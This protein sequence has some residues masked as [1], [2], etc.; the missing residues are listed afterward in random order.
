MEGEFHSIIVRMPN[1][2]GNLVMATP[3]LEDLRT[4]FPNAEITAMCLSHIAPL[5][6]HDSTIDKLFHFS[7]SK[8][9]F[10][11]IDERNIVEKLKKGQYDVGILLTNS[12]SSAWRFWRGDVHNKIGFKTQCR[13]MFLD[14]PLPLPKNRARQHLVVTYK[15]LLTPLGIPISSIAP[16]LSVLKEEIQDAWKFVKRFGVTTKNKII[17]ISPGADYGPAKC[18]LPERFREV[19]QRLIKAHPACVIL[20]FGKISQKDLIGKICTNLP[21][22]VINLA[23]QTNLRE[24]MALIKIC[25]VV[26]TNDSGPMHIADS[27]KTP[28]LALFGPTDPVISSPYRQNRSIIQKEIVCAPCFQRECPTD[29]SCMTQITVEE[30]VDALLEKITQRPHDVIPK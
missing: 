6:E 10:R 5:L 25:S 11:R 18:Y 9:F 8:K 4:T 7:K 16:H 21:Y 3:V 14:K 20:F 29:S 28:L 15:T 24:L 19:A 26:L 23:G 1:W 17:G 22:R 27:L 12:F 30:V 13:S 2:I